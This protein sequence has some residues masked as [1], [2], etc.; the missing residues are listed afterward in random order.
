MVP[1]RPR[2][3]WRL[4]KWIVR[5]WR[6]LSGSRA[7]GARG[8][9]SRR[10]R[11]GTP[12]YVIGAG[13]WA[14]RRPLRLGRDAAGR[15]SFGR[16]TAALIRQTRRRE[17]RG[18]LAAR[19]VLRRGARVGGRRA[20]DRTG[21]SRHVDRD[22][23]P[24][25]LQNCRTSVDRA[26][27]AEERIAAAFAFSV[28][29][30]RDAAIGELADFEEET[31]RIFRRM[32]AIPATT[33]PG[34]AAKV[35]ALLVHA[36]LDD[37]HGPAEELDGDNEMARALLGEFAGMTEEELAGLGRAARGADAPLSRGT[38]SRPLENPGP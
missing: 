10:A 21:Y 34:R 20:R 28:E 35:R 32:M 11:A 27:P 12:L 29:T 36:M 26:G 17:A 38:R 13:A 33:Q 8:R 15:L 24:V 37:W 6:G 22:H 4:A 31:D 3:K 14:T 7:V 5:G 23:S 19:D 9:P 2:A 18:G 16:K 25:V 30:G 1:N